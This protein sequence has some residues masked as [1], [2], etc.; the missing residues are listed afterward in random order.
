MSRRLNEAD[1]AERAISLRR[2]T[3]MAKLV[4]ELLSDLITMVVVVLAKLGTRRVARLSSSRGW[5]GT[6]VAR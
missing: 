2:K 6:A 4:L 5:E 1:E 3:P